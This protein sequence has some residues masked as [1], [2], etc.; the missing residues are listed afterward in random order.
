MKT[1]GA[2][3]SDFSRVLI[4]PVCSLS[5]AFTYSEEAGNCGGQ[6]RN[7]SQS[8]SSAAFSLHSTPIRKVHVSYAR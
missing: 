7:P 6:Q 4:A 5:A 2:R 1:H 3:R 8:V